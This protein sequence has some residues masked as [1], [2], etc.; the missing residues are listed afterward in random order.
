[1]IHTLHCPAR[2]RGEVMINPSLQALISSAHR[3]E[4]EPVLVARMAS[5]SGTV[6]VSRTWETLS[7]AHSRNVRPGSRYLEPDCKNTVQDARFD[8][9]AGW[10][11]RMSES[12]L[13]F[14]PAPSIVHVGLSP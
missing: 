2:F 13:N 5:S 10:C 8:F 3:A 7:I 12:N 6:H 14:Y 1:M 9:R 11:S 4:R